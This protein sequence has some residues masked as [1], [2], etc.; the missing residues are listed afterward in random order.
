[1]SDI[2]TKRALLT[3]IAEDLLYTA[4]RYVVQKLFENESD[5][6]FKQMLSNPGTATNNF[7]KTTKPFGMYE[8]I[9]EQTAL[10]SGLCV[11]HTIAWLRIEV[12]GKFSL[13]K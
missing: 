9:H 10:M 5:L 11:F 4:Y 7:M 3:T 13:G 8:I 2:N 1:V 12:W 6:A